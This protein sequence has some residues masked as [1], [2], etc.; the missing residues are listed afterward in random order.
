MRVLIV[1]PAPR[2]SLKGNRITALRWARMLRDLGHRVGIKQ[3]FRGERC[4]LL[5]ALH[6]RRSA[7]S[8]T[9]FRAECP[10]KPLVVALTGTDLYVDV[11]RHPAAKRSLLLADRLVVLQAYGLRELQP[12][13]REKARVIYQSVSAPVHRRKPVKKMFRVCVLGHL[14]PVKDPFRAA[15]AARRLPISSRVNI[16]QIGAALNESMRK[17]ATAE[18][19]SN[20]RYRWLGELSRGKCMRYLAQSHLL[21]LTSKS[22]GGANVIS[23]AVV[24]DVPVLSSHISGSIGLLGE[25]YA[26]YFAVGDTRGLAELLVRAESDSNFYQMLSTQ[27]KRVKPL[28]SPQRERASWR[29]LLAELA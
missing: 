9:R 6:A 26:G 5:V 10:D 7:R 23:E 16:L 4:D 13:M 27:C 1:T 22:E 3:E 18:S 8:V 19:D 2:G 29:D 24:L 17:R 14:R 15:M 12:R 28:F 21:L 11:H 20:A 25:D